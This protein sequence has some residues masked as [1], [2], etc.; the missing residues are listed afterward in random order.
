MDRT[1][2]IVAVASL[3]LIAFKM[4]WPLAQAQPGV[5]I[6]S[7]SPRTVNALAYCIARMNKSDKPRSVDCYD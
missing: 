7:I 1:F 3:A 4:S 2:K 5:H 6:E